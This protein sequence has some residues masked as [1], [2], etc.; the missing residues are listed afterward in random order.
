MP[1]ILASMLLRPLMIRQRTKL[2]WNTI[3]M[4]EKLKKFEVEFA[5]EIKFKKIYNEGVCIAVGT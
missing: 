4:Q 5:P 2:L 1:F 3:R